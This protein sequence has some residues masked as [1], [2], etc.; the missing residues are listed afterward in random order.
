MNVSATDR[1]TVENATEIYGV[2]GWG[3][4]YLAVAED[5]HLLVT[6]SR[7]PSRAID[8]LKVVVRW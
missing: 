5:G 2:D 1:F 3:N 6:P 8:V 7:D 4:G